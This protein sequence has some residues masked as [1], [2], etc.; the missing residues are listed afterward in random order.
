MITRKSG[1][2][3]RHA[4]ITGADSDTHTDTHTLP[5]AVQCNR[6]GEILWNVISALKAPDWYVTVAVSDTSPLKWGA[7][8]GVCVCVLDGGG[9]KGLIHLIGAPAGYLTGAVSEA[10]G[11]WCLS[12]K[13]PCYLPL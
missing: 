5:L 7:G 2:S 13:H 1:H 11:G 9:L 10:R 4:C 8:S 12:I 3:D 6:A